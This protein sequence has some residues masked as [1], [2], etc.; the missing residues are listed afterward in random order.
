[1]LTWFLLLFAVASLVLL[2][3]ILKEAVHLLGFAPNA[4]RSFHFRPS[5][6]SLG[7]RCLPAQI[8]WIG[9][10]STDTSDATNWQG[11]VLPTDS[12]EVFFSNQATRSAMVPADKKLSAQKLSVSNGFGEAGYDLTVNGTLDL[13]LNATAGDSTWASARQLHMGTQSQFDIHGSGNMIFSNG[14]FTSDIGIGAIYVT[15][16]AVL[17]FTASANS[18]DGWIFVGDGDSQ[19]DVVIGNLTGNLVGAAL[20]G[21]T[22]S[23]TGT[24]TMN[25]TGTATASIGGITGNGT[26]QNYGKFIRNGQTSEPYYPQ[27]GYKFINAGE[28]SAVPF[29]NL[30]FT[31]EDVDHIAFVNQSGG[32]ITL[33]DG[34]SIK[35]TDTGR[36]NQTGGTFKVEGGWGVGTVWFYMKS[37]FSGGSLIIAQDGSYESLN[38]GNNDVTFSNTLSVYFYL[39][40]SSPAATPVG[41]QLLIGGGS[42]LTI[43]NSQSNKPT[44]YVTTNNQAPVAGWAFDI[45][46]TPNLSGQFDNIIFQ[47]RLTD[48]NS[49]TVTYPG[50]PPRQVLLTR[51]GG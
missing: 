41:S 35:T 28:F 32:V 43:D 7:D 39:D 30:K 46:D 10:T 34:V 22:V 47:G 49:Y 9:G 13:S 44:L 17:Q 4:K 36:F 15:G 51:P 37:T 5:V 24:F 45:I 29:S 3:A 20:D 14:G 1:M 50:G 6:D 38:F 40:G 19:G 11:G 48:Q 33:G 26:F 31:G 25:Q 23:S 21:I 2:C 8:V 42:T 18:I 27:M 16:G 12:D